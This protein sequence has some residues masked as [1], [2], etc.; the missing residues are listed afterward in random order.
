ME[1][2]EKSLDLAAKR[3]ILNIEGD[4]IIPYDQWK[5]SDFEIRTVLEYDNPIDLSYKRTVSVLVSPYANNT[6]VR[7]IK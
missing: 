7:H 6:E 4:E 2:A 3:L 5:W 1:F